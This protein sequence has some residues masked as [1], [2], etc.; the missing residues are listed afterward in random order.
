MPTMVTDA[1]QARLQ[2]ATERAVHEQQGEPVRRR[3]LIVLLSRYLSE[4][5]GPPPT[6][7][8]FEVIAERV[9]LIAAGGPKADREKRREERTWFEAIE[10]AVRDVLTLRNNL[11]ATTTALHELTGGMGTNVIYFAKILHGFAEEG[12][13]VRESGVSRAGRRFYLWSLP[14]A[15]VR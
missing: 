9:D 11:P 10:R 1:F 7:E 3:E 13:L 14:D 5:G 12:K 2:V 15:L 8:Q 6:V 4:D